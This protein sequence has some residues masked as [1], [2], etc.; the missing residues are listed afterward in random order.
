MSEIQVTYELPTSPGT[1]RA[2]KRPNDEWK[3]FVVLDGGPSCG[4]YINDIYSTALEAMRGYMWG[5]RVLTEHE[6]QMSEQL[7]LSQD[8]R[9]ADVE[10]LLVGLDKLYVH[11]DVEGER[12]SSLVDLSDVKALIDGLLA[13]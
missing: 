1:Y 2:K 9:K 13:K 10:W 3:S 8:Q 11:G 7:K 12:G 5:G 4:L 6:L